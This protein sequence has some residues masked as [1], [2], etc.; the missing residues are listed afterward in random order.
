MLKLFKRRRPKHRAGLMSGR[1]SVA[2]ALAC[3]SG[4]NMREYD[5]DARTR[6]AWLA[7]ADRRITSQQ[8]IVTAHAWGMNLTQ[9]HQL[10]DWDRAEARRNITV[11]PRFQP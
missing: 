1:E 7:E 9:W 10:T 6:D 2:Y 4:E 11:A 5:T 3:E 8:D